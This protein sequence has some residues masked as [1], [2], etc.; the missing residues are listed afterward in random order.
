MRRINFRLAI[1][2][3]LIQNVE[4]KLSDYLKKRGMTQTEFGRLLNPPMTQMHISH[5]VN[6]RVRI[7]LERAVEIEEVTGG[8]VTVRDWMP[9]EKAA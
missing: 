9:Q 5:V 8:E 1:R 4:M 2:C 7:S 3:V 6:G